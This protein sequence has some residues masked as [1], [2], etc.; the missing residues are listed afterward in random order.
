MIANVYLA[1]EQIRGLQGTNSVWKAS[2]NCI[3]CITKGAL[4]EPGF[5]RTLSS[6]R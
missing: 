4:D 2:W 3:R 6:Q 1:L 5:G